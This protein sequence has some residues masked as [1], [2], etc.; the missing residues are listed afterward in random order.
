MTLALTPSRSTHVRLDARGTAL[1]GVAAMLAPLPATTIAYLTDPR[2]INGASVWAKPMHFEL[3]IAIHLGTLA[4]LVPFLSQAWQRSR[5]IGWSMQVAVLS[6]I[7]EITYISLQAARGHASHFNTET[8]LEIAMY[9]LMGV[10]AT[11]IVSGS[12]IFGYGLWRSPVVPRSEQLKRGAA[13]GL[14]L[15]SAA[16]LVIAGYLSQQHGHWVGGPQTDAHGLP[17]LGWATRGGDLRVPHFFATH[18]MQALPF[19]GWLADRLG[20]GRSGWLM[21]AAS[22]AYFSGVLALFGEA[23]LGMPFISV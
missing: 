15:G 3:S 20:L 16:T 4:L 1:T 8:G 22:G 18:A 13:L 10:G 11:L 5:L 23:L 2:T 12:A 19:I 14:M 9:A 7:L 21:A 6:A 17:F